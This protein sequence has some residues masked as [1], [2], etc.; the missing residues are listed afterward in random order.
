MEMT[1]LEIA[2]EYRTAANKT[3]QIKVLAELNLCSHRRIAE[4][5]QEQGEEL[6]GHWKEK[7]AKG[8]KTQ[9]RPYRPGSAPVTAGELRD[10]IVEAVTPDTSSASLCSA[11]RSALLSPGKPVPDSFPD[12]ESPQGEGR[13]AALSADG[14]PASRAGGITWP[15]YSRLMQIIGRLEGVGFV[16]EPAI[17]PF[18]FGAVEGLVKLADEIKPQ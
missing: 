6:P 15:Q 14:D 18:Y 9:P 8:L 17:P 2:S 10:A 7:L 3:K 12:G 1:P 16:L 13:S 5:L 11:P 4:I